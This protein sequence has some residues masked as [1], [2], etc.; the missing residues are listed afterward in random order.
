M[1][2]SSTMCLDKKRYK[3]FVNLEGHKTGGE[4]T[5]PPNLTVTIQRSDIVIVDKRQKTVS[6]FELAMPA[7]L[8]LDIAHT[9]KMNSYSHFS[10][11]IKSH[12]VALRFPLRSA[13]I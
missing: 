8:R 3:C 2:I 12:T 6:I 5:I 7:E 10:T 9:L 4:V 1:T 13:H 11:D